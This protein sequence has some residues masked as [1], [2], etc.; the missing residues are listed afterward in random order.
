MI[1]RTKTAISH[2]PGHALAITM[3]FA[4]ALLVLALVVLL[5]YNTVTGAGG[6]DESPGLDQPVT[7]RGQLQLP[8]G[9]IELAF[10][11]GGFALPAPRMASPA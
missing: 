11:S 6:Q 1:T 2:H 7:P 4:V 9:S 5:I 10:G 3:R 8:A